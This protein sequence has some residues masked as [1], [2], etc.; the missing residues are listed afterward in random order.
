MLSPQKGRH[1]S[2]HLGHHLLEL[3]ELYYHLLHLAELIEHPVDISDGDAA[4]LGNSLA[5]ARIE[6]FGAIR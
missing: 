2:P 4:A 1:C 6:D 5:A 3:A